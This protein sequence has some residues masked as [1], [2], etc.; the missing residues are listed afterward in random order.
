LLHLIGCDPLLREVRAGTQDRN[1]E[2]GTEAEAT[3][4][5]C[6]LA[7]SACFLIQ[8]RTTYLGVTPPTVGWVL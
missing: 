8:H 6:L 1:L 3:E 2:A 7:C 5:H 4:E